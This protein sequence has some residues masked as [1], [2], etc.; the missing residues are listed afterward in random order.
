MVT[1]MKRQ[2]AL[3]KKRIQQIGFKFEEEISEMLYLEH[4]YL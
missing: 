1:G 2:R 3:C 4:K